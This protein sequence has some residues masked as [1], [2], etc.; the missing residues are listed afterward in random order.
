MMH[1][2]G[3]QAPAGTLDKLMATWTA[4]LISGVKTV[5]GAPAS[6]ATTGVLG[7]VTNPIAAT[8]DA[9]RSALTGA[10]RESTLVSPMNYLEGF[11]KGIPAAKQYL[12]TG[13][14][15]RAPVTD[16]GREVNFKHKATG[17]AV[18]GVFRVMGALDRPFYYG[19]KA[20]SD[21]EF[22]K[23]NRLNKDKPAK[24]TPEEQAEFAEFEARKSVLDYDTLLSQIAGGVRRAVDGQ[25]DPFA[26]AVGKVASTVNAPFV[27]VPS[28]GL[29]R[30]IDFSPMGVGLHAV[31]QAARMKYGSQKDFNWRD[32]N[33]A[34]AESATGTGVL[35]AGYGLAMNNLVSGEYP[36][37][38]PKEQARWAA[39]RITPNSV[40]IGPT[41]VSMNYLGPVGSLIQQGKRFYDSE[42]AG[43]N[44]AE[45]AVAAEAGVARDALN[46]SY[47]QGINS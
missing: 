24:Y 9:T 11:R 6:N 25:T 41:W 42:K 39:E 2:I 7:A 5:T 14:D 27:R 33:K 47:L 12:K 28:A 40:K 13:I 21:A 38:D 22:A 45:N 31:K 15:E 17:N 36:S 46:Q 4:G 26:R 44:F 18:N 3:K 16:I 30:M 37:D 20:V 8:L 19:Q 43:G 35:V 10:P 32:M 34:I 23:L 29:E 1:F